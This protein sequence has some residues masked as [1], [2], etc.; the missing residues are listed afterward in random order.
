MKKEKE[1]KIYNGSM[2]NHK[3]ALIE[4]VRFV[5]LDI[6]SPQARDIQYQFTDFR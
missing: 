3:E 6:L 4:S 1:R 2:A 5:L